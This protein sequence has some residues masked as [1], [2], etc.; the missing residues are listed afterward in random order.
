LVCL[1]GE[2]SILKLGRETKNEPF[3]PTL[4][5][6]WVGRTWGEVCASQQMKP[7]WLFWSRRQPTHRRLESSVWSALQ[8]QTQS[9]IWRLFPIS[10][11]QP[12]YLPSPHRLLL[13]LH[14]SLFA[15]PEQD[16]ISRWDGNDW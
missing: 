4:K 13:S 15:V 7:Q 2:F 11:H 14:F 8:D 3:V 1:S 16:L 12:H 6:G 9:H 10:P 5:V